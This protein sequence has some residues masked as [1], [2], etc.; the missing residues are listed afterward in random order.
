MKGKRYGT[1][2]PGID[3]SCE[4]RNPER[5]PSSALQKNYKTTALPMNGMMATMPVAGEA[6]FKKQTPCPG[7]SKMC[8][9]CAGNRKKATALPKHCF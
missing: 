3:R 2:L 7:C 9:G 1:R 6:V 4:I 8:P 5:M